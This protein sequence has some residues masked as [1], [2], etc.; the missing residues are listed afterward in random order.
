MA[1]RA[2][3]WGAVRK[4]DRK[5]V[6]GC[7]RGEEAAWAELWERYGPLVKAVSRRVGCDGEEAREVLQ[8]VALVTLQRLETLREPEKLAGWLA[9]IARLQSLEVIRQRR[10][11]AELHPWSAVHEP[12]PAGEMQRDEELAVL[13][14]ALLALDDRCRRILGRLDLKEPPDSYQEV[15]EAEGLA[16]SSVGP[17]RRRCLN[18]LR[19]LV[20]SVSRSRDSDH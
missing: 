16:T 6:R 8:R 2:P 3:D 5:L 13:R 19:K 20:E 9:G 1:G 11:S 18:R 10:P 12:D 7:L 15:A 14:Q 4:R 17:I